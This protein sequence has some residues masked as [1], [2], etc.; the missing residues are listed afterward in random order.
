MESII[1]RQ[2]NEEIMRK[3]LRELRAELKLGEAELQELQRR[4][5]QLRDTVLRISGA[6]QVLEEL[7]PSTDK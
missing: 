6:I 5:G 2:V 4:Q 3:R 1:D 7:L